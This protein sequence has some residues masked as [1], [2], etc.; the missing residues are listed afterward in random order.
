MI[1]INAIVVKAAHTAKKFSAKM[2]NLFCAQRPVLR[3]EKVGYF[4]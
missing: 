1:H 2:L 3:G 4:N